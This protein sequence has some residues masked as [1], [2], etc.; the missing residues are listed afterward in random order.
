MRFALTKLGSYLH[1][2]Q[3][4][5]YGNRNCKG[6]HANNHES[7]SSSSSASCRDRKIPSS[8]FWCHHHHFLP[9]LHQTCSDNEQDCH[10][11][12]TLRCR[13]LRTTFQSVQQK[14]VLPFEAVASVPSF[15]SVGLEAKRAH[16]LFALSCFG[17][18]AERGRSL[19]LS[20]DG[21]GVP[22]EVAGAFAVRFLVPEK[23][24]NG[25]VA[26]TEREDLKKLV[27]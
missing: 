22:A 4:E 18:G 3:N 1:F 23:L 21:F 27:L 12:V 26:T 11:T 24:G 17:P 19:Q 20:S 13:G 8:S 6:L 10:I 16:W 25:G 14:F 15:V 2:T 9:P 7:P 5:D